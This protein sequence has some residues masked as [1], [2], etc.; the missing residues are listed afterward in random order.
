MSTTLQNQPVMGH[1]KPSAYRLVSLIRLPAASRAEV[2]NEAVIYHEY[3]SLRVA[4]HSETVD[5]SLTHGSIVTL[6][7]EV[8][9][10]EANDGACSRIG[11]LE[12]ISRPDPELNI[13]LTIPAS[14]VPDRNSIQRAAA[15]WD[16]LSRPFQYLLN[17]VFWD[18][19]RFYRYVTGPVSTANDAMVSGGDLRQT[20]AMAERAL[21]L[22]RGLNDVSTSVVVAAAFLLNAGKAD[23]YHRSV[24]GYELS[25]RGYWIGSKYTVLEWLAVARC[26]VSVPED[27][28]IALVHTLVAVRGQP[29]H[30]Q[31]TEAAILA[32]ANRLQR[33]LE[34]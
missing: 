4:W 28:Y 7:G 15:L 20:V 11:G 5:S 33:I 3:Q 24:G 8:S 34:C 19:G 23:Y 30:A 6:R 22:T 2:Y 25:E 26:K 16:K 1:G 14:W 10:P 21:M 17:S 13:F 12:L 9:N 32:V 27:Q 18:G 29:A 31:S